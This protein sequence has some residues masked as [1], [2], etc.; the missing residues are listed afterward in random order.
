MRRCVVCCLCANIASRPASAYYCAVKPNI[1]SSYS[2]T[3][4]L[5]C[6]TACRTGS[7]HH[8]VPQ[9]I[10]LKPKGDQLASFPVSKMSHFHS[11]KQYHG[12]LLSTLTKLNVCKILGSYNTL[13][14]VMYCG[15]FN[16]FCNVCVCVGG[17]CN[18]WVCMCG[19]CNV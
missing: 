1:G 10:M 17:F 2:K 19:F 9:L 12:V 4:D 5:G 7:G 14:F 15:C 8:P 3:M 6:T 16:L 18:V 11:P 13:V